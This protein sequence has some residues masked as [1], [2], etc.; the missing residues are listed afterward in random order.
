MPSF[1]ALAL[2]TPANSEFTNE[3]KGIEIIIHN[4]KC[5]NAHNETKEFG[6]DPSKWI[7]QW[8]SNC[9][10]MLRRS[11]QSVDMKYFFVPINLKCRHRFPCIAHSAGSGCLLFLPLVGHLCA[12]YARENNIPIPKF[13]QTNLFAVPR[14]RYGLHEN[15]GN[16][17]AWESELFA[18]SPFCAHLQTDVSFNLHASN[19]SDE[20]I[21]ILPKRLNAHSHIQNETDTGWNE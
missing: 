15:F 21:S 11:G 18:L 5:S 9:F 19:I 8:Y 4:G 3:Q 1:R 20:K 2:R 17:V 7:C 12:R 6:R 16:N 13:R 10:S 14:D